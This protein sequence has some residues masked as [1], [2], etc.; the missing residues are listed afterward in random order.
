MSFKKILSELNIVA[1]CKKYG[2]SIWQCP[3]FLFLLMGLV[4]MITAVVTY[5]LGTRV[6]DPDTVLLIVFALTIVLFV[7]TFS[8]T[9]SLEGLA[10]ANQLKSEF[11]SIVSHQLR[12][13]LSNLKWA[14]ELLMSGRLG[15]IKGKQS[16]YLEILKDNTNR[17]GELVS[18][19]LTVSRIEQGRFPLEKTEFSLPELAKEI[20]A[21]YEP[22]AKASQVEIK[23][24]AAANLPKAFAD[25]SRIKIVAENLLD[26]AIRYTKDKGEVK[27]KIESRSKNV[28]FA[29][30]DT[31]VGIPQEDQKHI[32]QK[33]FR[34]KNVLKYQTQGTGLGLYIAKSI[35]KKS[36][37]K[38]GFQS[39]ESK[40]STFWFILP[41][42]I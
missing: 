35:I 40:G 26:N 42:K 13:P 27:I 28:F 7:V 2:V 24:E 10:E 17:M 37:G 30:Q 29:V 18:D 1:R 34:S 23:F 8:I 12:S 15:E 25:A 33:F 36:G 4:I 21:E 19:L 11:I 16:E 5:T 6:A 22:I 20:L 38:I 3:Q 41:T 39:K 14:V 9:R 32:F 31:G